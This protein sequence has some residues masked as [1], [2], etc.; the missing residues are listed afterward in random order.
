MD[1]DSTNKHSNTNQI[2]ATQ[3][4]KVWV[5]GRILN[6]FTEHLGDNAKKMK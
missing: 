6:N 3:S 2:C 1:S 4:M 5:N